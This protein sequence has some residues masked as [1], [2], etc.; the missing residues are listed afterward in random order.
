VA[1][2]EYLKEQVRHT[3]GVAVEVRLMTSHGRR[4]EERDILSLASVGFFFL[5]IGVIWIVTP[6][7]SQEVVDFSK[8]FELKEAFEN[9]FLPFP[10]HHHP[11]VYT[12]V[13]RFC[14]VFGLFQI[15]I[16]VLRFVFREP[17]DKI[18]GTF[19]GMVFWLG[20]GFVANMLSAGTIKWFVFLGWI[21]VLIG[22]SLV[23]RS[24]VVLL[25][26]LLLRKD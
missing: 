25:F 19:S 13:T 7:L 4:R 16:L 20:A 8:D 23:I 6:N 3:L 15:F 21:I 22:L 24:L 1:T 5:L 14:F 9:V 12:A 2:S 18:A 26:E 10:A 17:A 11:V